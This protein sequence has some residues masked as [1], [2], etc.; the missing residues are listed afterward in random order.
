MLKC[1]KH[2]DL[3]ISCTKPPVPLPSKGIASDKRVSTPIAARLH[4][5]RTQYP[6]EED[7][8]SAPRRRRRRAVP[9]RIDL[10]P[11][12]AI[13]PLHRG[14]VIMD[15]WYLQEINKAPQLL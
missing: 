8:P 1:A 2:V 11:E 5:C 9:V 3:V 4:F 15:L 13:C 12:Q 6:S 14:P 10:G 7:T